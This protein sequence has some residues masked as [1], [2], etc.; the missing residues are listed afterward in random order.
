MKA[1][2][3]LGATAAIALSSPALSANLVTNGSFETGNFSGWTLTNVGGGTA[4]VVI[5]YNQAGNYPVGAFGEAIPTD[6]GGGTYAAYF[7][8]DTAKPDSLSQSVNVVAGQAYNLS[9]DYYVPQN[10]YNNPNDATLGF[11]INGNQVGSLLQ[12]G[13]PS[14]TPPKTWQSFTTSYVAGATGP[15]TLSFNFSGLGSTAA[16]FAIDK[17]SM[18]AVPEPATW[19]MM[20]LGFGIVGSSARRRKVNVAFA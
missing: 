12:A 16:D 11:A 10:G 15:A 2:L 13:S 3:A 7:S 19:A 8:S 14:G 9:F 20:L 1:L 6:V 4:P 18:T 5:Q 17:V